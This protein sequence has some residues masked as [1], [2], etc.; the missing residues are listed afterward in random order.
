MPAAHITDVLPVGH[1][2]TGQ[3]SLTAGYAVIGDGTNPVQMRAITDNTSA[4]AVSANNNLITAN[5][6][7]YHKGNSNLITVG[8]ITSGKWHGT[9][10]EIAYGGTGITSNPSMLVNL[11]SGDADTVF[12]ASP[13]PGVIG[14][15]PGDKGG[16]GQ[17][18]LKA[19]ANALINA[20][21]T[22][23]SQPTMSD[24]YVSQYAGGGTT[25]TTYHRRPVQQL[26]NLFSSTMSSSGNSATATKLATARTLNVDLTR[27]YDPSG[28]PVVKSTF[29]GSADVTN[30]TVSGTLP[31]SRGGTGMGS[32]ANGQVLIGSSTG[33]IAQRAVTNNTSAIAVT[34]STNLITANTLYYHKGNSNIVTVGTITSGAWHGST[35]GLSYG[36]TGMTKSPQLKVDLGESTDGGEWVTLFDGDTNYQRTIK[37][38]NVLP[39]G[40]GGT[41]L[42]TSPSL[43]VNLGSTT[44]ADV[45]QVSPRPG[46]IGTLPVGNGGTGVTSIANIKAG[47][48]ADG[49]TIT[50]T[51][52]TK[53]EMNSLL[54]AS[55]AMIFKGVVNSNSD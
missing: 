55:D 16:T 11:G 33:G 34:A 26:Y 36:G 23:S 48:D 17:A 41:G 52:A 44:A 35:I 9:T 50:T 53:T 19:G 46:V 51:Y 45:L 25:T 1:G 20:L 54:A 2:G 18:S 4:T 49:N 38:V 15:L 22:G 6:L 13:R 30:I 42:G 47:K 3:A 27:T 31:V 21:D 5:T 12:K 32:F 8:T 40:K 39:I 28:N 29:D 14:T 37:V 10:I 24:Y 7:Y 43:L